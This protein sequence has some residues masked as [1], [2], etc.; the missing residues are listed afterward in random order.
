MSVPCFNQGSSGPVDSASTEKKYH[1]KLCIDYMFCWPH[2]WRWPYRSLVRW[3]LC[4]GERWLLP[5]GFRISRVADL[6][7]G[8]FSPAW[9]HTNLRLWMGLHAEG[10][11]DDAGSGTYSALFGQRYV[12]FKLSKFQSPFSKEIGKMEARHLL[13]QQ[14]K[15][16]IGGVLKLLFQICGLAGEICIWKSLSLLWL[17]CLRVPYHMR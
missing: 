17:K 12:A 3:G 15:W 14:Y 11:T 8:V 7:G 9:L 4:H 10:W 2:R 13:D 16:S 6:Q 5:E 1:C